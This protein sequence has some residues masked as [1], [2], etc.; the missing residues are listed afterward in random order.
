MKMLKLFLSESIALS[1][2]NHPALFIPRIREYDLPFFFHSLPHFPSFSSL[3]QWIRPSKK[4]PR[5]SDP[6]WTH[7]E[8]P[9][10]FSTMSTWGFPFLSSN[11]ISNMLDFTA[12]LLSFLLLRIAALPSP[13]SPSHSLSLS[14]IEP[15]LQNR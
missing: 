1:R 6:S 8:T 4:N 7:D 11:T 2:R 10:F 12:K 5:L 3:M 13:S 15:R 9:L 14:P